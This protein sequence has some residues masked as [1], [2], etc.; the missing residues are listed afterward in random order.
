[1]FAPKVQSRWKP[2]VCSDWLLAG[3]VCEVVFRLFWFVGDPVQ[4][5]TLNETPNQS[6]S[7]PKPGGEI[8]RSR[9]QRANQL[10]AGDG[11]G[12]KCRSPLRAHV[13]GIGVMQPCKGWRC[14]SQGPVKLHGSKLIMLAVLNSLENVL[15][16]IKACTLYKKHAWSY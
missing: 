4:V 2:L 9:S 10:T 15:K 6:I 13:S 11:P 12:W 8:N 14:W 7:I 1:M 16:G 3:S 5:Y